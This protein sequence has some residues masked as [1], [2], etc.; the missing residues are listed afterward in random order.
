[1][2]EAAPDAAPIGGIG[3]GAVQPSSSD[4]ENIDLCIGNRQPRA[5]R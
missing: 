2:R 3:T 4:L 5:D 1:V